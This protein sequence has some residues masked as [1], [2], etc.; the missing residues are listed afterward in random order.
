MKKA[1]LILLIAV[2]SF[3]SSQ[4]SELL[5]ELDQ[6]TRTQNA[7]YSKLF[8]TFQS[9]IDNKQKQID[10]LLAAQ[11]ADRQDFNNQIQLLKA[12]I[13][14]L[15][16]VSNNNDTVVLP[17]VPNGLAFKD[18]YGAG[19][20]ATGG[21]GGIVV[22]V[23]NLKD[24]GEGSFRWA[25]TMKEPRYI[26]FD[27]SGVINLKTVIYI[28]DENS[29]NF[30]INAKSAPRGGITIIGSEIKFG[31]KTNNQIWRY[32]S[33]RNGYK[34]KQSNFLLNRNCLV[35]R[36]SSN[37]II[38]HC[39]FA[40]SNS[41]AVGIGTSKEGE[42][43]EKITIQN[44]LIGHSSQGILVGNSAGS[45]YGAVSVLRNV[46]STTGWRHPKAGGALQLDVINN[47]SHNWKA[48]TLRLDGYDYRLNHIGNYY[49]AGFVT[50]KYKR[51]DNALFATYTNLTMKPLIWDSDNY[52]SEVCR[53]LGYPE[54]P[55]KAWF[56][57]YDSK[58][59]VDKA[60]FV[61]ERLPIQGREIP[62][63]PSVELKDSLL[64]TVGATLYID[65]NGDVQYYRSALDIE[66]VNYVSTNAQTGYLA[67]AQYEA[68]ANKII[69]DLPSE[70]RP[71]NWY[72][73]NPHIPEVWVKDNMPQGASH[74]DLS[75]RG[76]TWLDE[77]LEQ[78]Y[79]D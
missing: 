29:G 59:P 36:S 6:A 76:L 13:D 69:Y 15:V 28:D 24:S 67:P 39:S 11:K 48:R 50:M 49:Q 21:R 54:D 12:Q 27:V 75:P 60:W 68:L 10:V 1:I 8:Q 78:D 63:L 16:S 64:P 56:P 30:T 22:H 2:S 17:P 23:T 43:G 42:Y 18:A 71:Q 3:A 77:Y 31:G 34:P 74:W 26:I 58:E 79:K 55:S 32:I 14:S 35:M 70:T 9:E 66:L 65:N 51:A 73:T 61:S 37:V 7:I 5:K 44:S 57:F 20:F 38:D 72:V 53:P 41:Q 52:I 46:I 47:I 25:I 40:F 19:A 62:V 33:F 4:T 45:T